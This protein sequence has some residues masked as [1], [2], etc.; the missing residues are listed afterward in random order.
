MSRGT[1]NFFAK[2]KNIYIYIYIYYKEIKIETKIILVL[3]KI[4]FS[5]VHEINFRYLFI[6]F[7]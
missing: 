6:Y 4:S 5:I 7:F 1:I 3:F 2:K